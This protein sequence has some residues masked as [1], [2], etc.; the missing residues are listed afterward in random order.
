MAPKRRL[1]TSSL[2]PP[3]PDKRVEVARLSDDNSFQHRPLDHRQA[4][5]RLL[6][7]LPDL[8]SRGSINCT[9]SH[10]TV[11]QAPYACLLYRWG[12]PQPS[13]RI[14]LDGQYFD[15][16]QNLFHFLE[17]FRK[18][19][20]SPEMPFWID[21]LCIDQQDTQERNHQVAWMVQVFSSAEVVYV[22]LGK[23][24]AVVPAA[25]SLRNW[26]SPSFEDLDLRRFNILPKY[27]YSNK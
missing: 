10:S 9:I 17:M 25:R 18:N 6:H 20:R 24:S 12:E 23:D 16:G 1:A 15:V 11:E 7:I 22:W 8:S 5:I 2:A 13:H 19:A 27:L 4:S 14:L 21:A 26:R 3:P